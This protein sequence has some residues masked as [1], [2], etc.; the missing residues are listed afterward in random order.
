MGDVIM[1][2]NGMINK[3]IG[4]AIMAIWGA[5]LRND[6]H[7]VLA[8]QAALEMKNQ[9]ENNGFGIP[10]ALRPQHRDDGGG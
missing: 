7:C 3:Y 1:Q 5:P 9:V 10:R 2:R 8:C 4:D 6:R